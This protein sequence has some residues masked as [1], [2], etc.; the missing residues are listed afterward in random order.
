MPGRGRSVWLLAALGV[1][2]GLAGAL[3]YFVAVF[4]LPAWPGIRNDAM[5]SW[6]LVAAG[7]ALS[8]AAVARAAPRRRLLPAL[9]LTA[10]VVVA[11]WFA[12]VLYVATVVPPAEGPSIGAST[13]DTDGISASARPQP[14]PRRIR[15]GAGFVLASA[16]SADGDLCGM[17][18]NEP[19]RA[20]VATTTGATPWLAVSS[21]MTASIDSAVRTS[22]S[23]RARCSPC[24][25]SIHSFAMWAALSRCD[26]IGVTIWYPAS[27]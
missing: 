20:E 9:L 17:A 12:V 24:A 19:A 26:V 2:L 15:S 4:R 14:V 23:A 27:P 25:S 16:R 21:A 5:P 13:R 1:A 8:I 7:L 11:A 6:L 10:N 18:A 22:A 3:G